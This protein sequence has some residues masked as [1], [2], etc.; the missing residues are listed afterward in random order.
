MKLRKVLAFGVVYT[1]TLKYT[2]EA[3]MLNKLKSC[4]TY[5]Y[6]MYMVL[7]LAQVVCG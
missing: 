1:A 6:M 2:C 5:V 4:Y 3:C 7:Q